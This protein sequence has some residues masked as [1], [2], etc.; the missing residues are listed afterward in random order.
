M[1]AETLIGTHQISNP[2]KTTYDPGKPLISIHVPKCAGTSFRAVLRHWFGK[3]FLEHY[4]NE[5]RAENPQKHDL[6]RFG[7][8]PVCI[9][10]HFNYRR[11]KGPDT[12]YPQATQFISIVRDP[13][14][15]HLS[16]YFYAKRHLSKGAL[17]RQGLP[18]D[19]AVFASIETYLNERPFSYLPAFFPPELNA[20]NCGDLL[21]EKYIYV[22]VMEDIEYCVGALAGLL[23]FPNL[24]ITHANATRRNEE[25]PQCLR[26]RF[27]ENNKTAYAIYDFARATYRK[28]PAA[29]LE[30]AAPPHPEPAGRVLP[31]IARLLGRT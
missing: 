16:N 3:G 19:P 4:P 24:G 14:E 6:A 1:H 12:F 17:F 28:V 8:K 15:L 7:A 30:A 29:A 26:D 11:G 23:G 10:G 25:I 18:R 21:A 20:A 13:F 9:H 2:Y 27:A 31:K 22:G 5:K